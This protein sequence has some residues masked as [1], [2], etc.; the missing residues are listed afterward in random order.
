M[1]QKHV[2]GGFVWIFG[3]RANQKQP[4][5]QRLQVKHA[6]VAGGRGHFAVEVVHI[7]FLTVNVEIRKLPP[8][9]K[10]NFVL[11]PVSAEKVDGVVN[12][13]ALALQ[14]QICV[15]NR[16]H[17]LLDAFHLAGRKAHVV[18]NVR[19]EP[20]ADG[21]VD[22]NPRLWVALSH[23][24]QKHKQ[25]GALIHAVAAR[26]VVSQQGDFAVACAECAPQRRALGGLTLLFADGYVVK[27][28]RFSGDVCRER[29]RSQIGAVQTKLFYK[30]EQRFSALRVYGMSVYFQLHTKNLLA[31][32][33]RAL[34]RLQE[35]MRKAI[36][37]RAGKAPVRFVSSGKSRRADTRCC[38]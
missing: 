7:V 37:P 23:G 22:A 2:L 35:R 20:R 25:H 14:R 18:T 31:R 8:L 29:P 21:V 30:V 9:Q 17:L 16:A 5:R 24:E 33:G 32:S 34:R 19:V 12:I 36:S 15:H 10:P 38:F 6:G 27:R 3:R 13:H 26:A 11:L 1:R 28:K 4:R